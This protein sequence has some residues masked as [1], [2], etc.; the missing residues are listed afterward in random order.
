[1]NAR[2]R[3]IR[4]VSWAVVRDGMAERHVYRRDVDI[5]LADGRVIDITPAPACWRYPG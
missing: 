5:H 1:M 3:L 2:P 4:N